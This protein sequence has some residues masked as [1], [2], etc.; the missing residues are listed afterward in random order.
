[1]TAEPLAIYQEFAAERQEQHQYALKLRQQRGW[2]VAQM[3]KTNFAARKVLLFGSLL[4]YQC[5][6]R[7]SDI[8]LAVWGLSDDSYYQAVSQVLLFNVLT[9]NC[10]K[11]QTG[12]DA[13]CGRYQLRFPMFVP[14]S[15]LLKI[16]IVWMNIVLFVML[17]EISTPLI[18]V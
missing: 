11:A 4:D 3:L 1:M 2:Q 10:R 8:D 6:H 9:L 16:V 5:M 13:C 15:L 17:S 12:I 18:Y 14:L 7:H